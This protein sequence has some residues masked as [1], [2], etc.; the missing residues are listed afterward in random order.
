[1]IR[2]DHT[3]SLFWWMTKIIELILGQYGEG[4]TIKFKA[5]RGT[6]LSPVQRIFPLEIQ[7]DETCLT[8]ERTG[9]G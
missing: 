9:K 3:K 2:D 1:M 7:A 4:H 5:Q 8:H 6:V